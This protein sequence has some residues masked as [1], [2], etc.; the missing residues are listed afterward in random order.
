[1]SA[2]IM[3][4]RSDYGYV[5]NKD[6]PIKKVIGLNISKFRTFNNQSLS[7]GSHVTV[8]S[9]RNGSMKTSLMGLVAHVF[10]SSSKDAFGKDLK[11][12]LKEVFKL[13][14]K[15]DKDKYI[16][17]I[18]IETTKDEKIS[19]PVS[20]Y[21]TEG[22]TQRHRVVL[23]GSEKG[24]G[25]FQYNTSFLNM[26]RLYPL[27]DTNASEDLSF[28]LTAQE[29]EDLKKFYERI[30]PSST[31]S[32][33]SPVH[34][35][36][37]K[38]TFGPQGENSLYDWSSISSGEDNL[39]AIFNRLLGFQRS[40]VKG[41][42]EGN[43]ILCIDEFESSLHPVA[44][45]KL[46]DYLYEWS[47]L[48]RVQIVISTHSLHLL[49]HIYLKHQPNLDASRVVINFVSKSTASDGNHPIIK[50]PPYDKAYKELTFKSPEQIAEQRKIKVFCE[51]EV[52]INFAKRLVKNRDILKLVEFS[53]T[54]NKDDKNNKGTSYSALKTLCGFP[55][56]LESSIVIF[57]ADVAETVTEN[58]KNKDFFMR[59]PDQDNLA[60]ERRIICF[61]IGLNNGHD[62]FVKFDRERD[63]FLSSMADYEI[64]LTIEDVKNEKKVPISKCKNWVASEKGDFNKYVTYYVS[65]IEEAATEFRS[66]FLKR[67]NS[68]NIGLG[69]PV[70]AIK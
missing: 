35:K 19:E 6:I 43:G 59:L 32:S 69:M 48:Y 26:K 38:T 39:G 12:S 44:Q 10:T 31:Y 21:F 55:V 62:F 22:K 17:D 47:R 46:F 15:F 13:S 9:G 64:P 61:I 33:F 1:M 50:N 41:N 60:L 20:I 23:S 63:I 11:T 7:L 66:E 51:D 65:H 5:E 58:I 56:L 2:V 34:Q 16:Y 24:D 54:V 45:L 52:A 29:A 3:K 70:V 49:Q 18:E 57:D 8:F 25:N 40:F 67:I 28:K 37:L 14:D 27:V 30:F 4:R 36:N 68:V 42:S 53:S